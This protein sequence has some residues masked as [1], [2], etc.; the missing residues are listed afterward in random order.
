MLYDFLLV[1]IILISVVSAMA[2]I[3]DKL[4]AVNGSWRISERTLLLL[5]LLGGSVIMFIV[6]RIIRHKT[7]HNKFMLGIPLIILLQIA[8]ILA[9][10]L[11]F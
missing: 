5:C 9:V 4:S 7:R 2:C 8:I 1:Y 3:I 11:N 6:M 10:Y